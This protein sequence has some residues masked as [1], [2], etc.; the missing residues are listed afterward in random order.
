MLRPSTL[1][2]DFMAYAFGSPHLAIALSFHDI[3]AWP[4]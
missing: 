1:G 3:E 2:E 4:Y